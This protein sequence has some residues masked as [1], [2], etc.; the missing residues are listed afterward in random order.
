MHK[1]RCL[2]LLVAGFVSFASGCQ[3]EEPSASETP[4][5][6][7]RSAPLEGV[8]GTWSTNAPQLTGTGWR[9][10]TLLDS[11]LVLSVRD[12]STGLYNPYSDTWRSLVGPYLFG[13]IRGTVT[14]LPSGKVLLAGGTLSSGN[15]NQAMLFDPA[16][17]SWSDTGSMATGRVDHTA[18]L[19]D[20]NLVLVVGGSYN[21]RGQTALA[22]LYDPT[23]GTWSSAGVLPEELSMHT[24]TQLYSGEVLVTGG[25]HFDIWNHPFSNPRSA[26]YVFQPAT[27]TWTP[28]GNM[29]RTR[30]GHVAVRLYSGNVLVAGGTADANDT[31]SDVYNPYSR[32]WLPGPSLPIPGPYVSATLLYSGEVLVLNSSGQGALYDASANAW[33]LAASAQ[34]VRG[35][36]VTV[37]LQTGHV[38]ALGDGAVERYTR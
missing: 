7:T 23:T 3:P 4:S 11:G 37:M 6:E 27:K 8:V 22:E 2:Y 38:L 33:R 34:Q 12:G 21:L 26:A 35:D 18:T 15:Q 30:M 19:L 25:T 32:Q 17:E 14:R 9:T 29:S 31:S 36:F 20:S 10:A 24:A 5:L 13:R 28:A 1:K 16:T